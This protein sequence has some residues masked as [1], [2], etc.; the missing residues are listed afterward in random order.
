MEKE[1]AKTKKTAL[2]KKST[3]GLDAK[4]SVGSNNHVQHNHDHKGTGA[5]QVADCGCPEYK[6]NEG[7]CWNLNS[8]GGTCNHLASEHS[9]D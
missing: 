5:C 7:T 6:D 8:A 3:R 1:I 2:A 9:G 4:T